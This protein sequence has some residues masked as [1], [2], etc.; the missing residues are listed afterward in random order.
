L[1][2]VSIKIDQSNCEDAIHFFRVTATQVKGDVRQSR[3]DS[4]DSDFSAI[5]FS[6]LTINGAG[7]DCIDLS[8]GK[9]NIRTASIS[10]C[11]DKGI[12][13]GE[14]SSVNVQQL[15]IDRAGIGVA[16]KDSSDVR[17]GRYLINDTA[18]CFAAYQKKTNYFGGTLN[19]GNGECTESRISRAFEQDGSKV[20]FHQP[21]K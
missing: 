19:L 9:Y 14:N 3:S 10:D 13:A 2:K 6:S 16:A 12:S 4:I 1:S 11:S 18:F 17:V 21:L 5:E 7:N 20:R 8:A 15:F